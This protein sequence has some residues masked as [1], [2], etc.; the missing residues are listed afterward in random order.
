MALKVKTEY[1]GIDKNGSNITVRDSTGIYSPNNLTGYGLPNIDVDDII[2]FIFT[3]SS[4]STEEL[5]R[6][7]ITDVEDI[8]SGKEVL[9][10][11]EILAG[12]LNTLQFEDGVY[13]LNEYVI[14]ND[15]LE[16]A[17][18]NEGDTFIILSNSVT[19][20]YLYK[21]DT[22][23]DDTGK[24]F[25]IDKSKPFSSTMIYL[26][27]ELKSDVESF[28]LGYR[29]NAKFLITRGFDYAMANQVCKPCSKNTSVDILYH[30]VMAEMSMER[31]DYAAANKLISE[32]FNRYCL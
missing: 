22:V 12:E 5:Y 27:E 11:A 15:D 2:K 16:V 32:S 23:L 7:D 31:G 6:L 30:K 3:L 8:V 25:T 21:F 19:Q 14:V 28:N 9:M 29:A 4:F 10:N 13:D 1:V 24:I 17:Q 26:T 20:E 18:A